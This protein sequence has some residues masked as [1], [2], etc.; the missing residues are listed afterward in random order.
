[1][2]S[3]PGVRDDAVVTFRVLVAVLVL[4]AGASVRIGL[5]QRVLQDERAIV[6][7]TQRLAEARE[8][9][10]RLQ[11]EAATLARVI[12]LVPRRTDRLR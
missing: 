4:T 6:E 2:P 10:T 5:R 8:R 11:L 1:M 12:D 3:Q 9:R 7:T